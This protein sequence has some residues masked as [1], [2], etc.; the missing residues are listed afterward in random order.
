MVPTLPPTTIKELEKEFADKMD[1]HKIFSS[2]NY[3]EILVEEGNLKKH[4]DWHA[5]SYC[6]G[7]TEGFMNKYIHKLNCQIISLFQKLS[8]AFVLKHINKLDLQAIS[9]QCSSE[10]LLIEIAKRI[11]FKGIDCDG[12][13]SFEFLKKNIEKIDIAGTFERFLYNHLT[14]EQK[15]TLLVASKLKFT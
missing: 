14:E 9:Y 8:E 2:N 5:L 15:T 11:D 12:R 6:R 1:W 10:T 13:C 4:I 3:V 7:L